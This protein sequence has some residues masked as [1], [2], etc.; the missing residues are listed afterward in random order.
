MNSKCCQNIQF[1]RHFLDWG[2][3]SVSKLTKELDKGHKAKSIDSMTDTEVD[4][5]YTS[6][7]RGLHR[8]HSVEF[9]VSTH[10]ICR[11]WTGHYIH[12]VPILHWK[13]MFNG[14]GTDRISYKCNRLDRNLIA[15]ML[16]QLSYWYKTQSPTE[17][18]WS[19]NH[20]FFFSISKLAACGKISGFSR[21]YYDYMSWIKKVC[22]LK[23]SWVFI[24]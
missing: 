20:N 13:W 9:C 21:S 2:W 4:G 1:E 10:F 5:L 18:Y 6:N 19:R 12:D 17:N 15:R 11:I 8:P 24:L 14:Y 16:Y 3:G 22:V 23:I 7:V